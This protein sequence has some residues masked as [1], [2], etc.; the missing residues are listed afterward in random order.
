MV[1][2]RP[3]YRVGGVTVFAED[4]VVLEGVT[5]DQAREIAADFAGVPA[6]S[7]RHERT[8]TQVDQWTLGQSRAL[9]LE[10]LRVDDAAGTEVYVARGN[11]EVLMLTTRR[12]RALAWAGA[13]PHWIYFTALR[14]HQPLW[15]DVVVWTS[16]AACV[17]ALLGLALAVTQMRRPRPFSLRDA[18][19]YRGMARWHYVTGAVFGIV[20]LTWAFSGLLSVEPFAWTNAEGLS[21]RAAAFSGGPP[22]LAAFAPRDAAGWQE[23]AGGRTIKSIRFTRIQDRDYYVVRTAPPPGASAERRGH[24]PYAVGDGSDS[25]RFLV[26][27]GSLERRDAPFSTESLLDRLGRALPE[28]S[29]PI[30][31]ELLTAYDSYYYSRAGERALPVL[32]VKFDDPAETWVYV[33]PRLGEVVS[34]LP[35]MARLERWLYNGLHSL[36]FSFW[37]DSALWWVGMWVLL[38]GGLV[39]SSL[40]LLMGLARVKRAASRA[41]GNRVRER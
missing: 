11:G 37:Y 25:T 31:S 19:P 2:G 34:V 32:R 36:D 5:L 9:P 16:A 40:G 24:R 1:L 30:A 39:T 38:L 28:G 29:V 6:S 13:I 12:D 3:A 27:A 18:I 8:L 41:G 4:G 26:A 14:T 10:K 21:V 17:L 22:D 7:V 15:Y 20:T 33:D 23:V 35:R